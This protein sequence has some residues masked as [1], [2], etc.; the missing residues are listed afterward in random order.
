MRT[1]FISEPELEFGAGRH[2]D[3]RFGLMNYGPLDYASRLAPRQIKLGVIGTP[4]TVEKV[5]VWL[6]RCRQEIAAKPSKLSNLFCRFPGFND[7]VAFR[8]SLILEPRL[9]RTIPERD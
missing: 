4:E 9:Q 7:D 3:I 8:A 2:I 6:D 5:Q 1:E